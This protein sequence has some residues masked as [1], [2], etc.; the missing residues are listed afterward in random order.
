M[1]E[2]YHWL[3]QKKNLFWINLLVNNR[4]PKS[5]QYNLRKNV[6]DT[7]SQM[8]K[9]VQSLGLF[10]EEG[11]KEWYSSNLRKLALNNWS[12]WSISLLLVYADKSWSNVRFAYN[13]KYING[14]LID[15]ALKK[16]RLLLEIESSISNMSRINLIVMGLPFNIQDKLDKEEI[17]NT[18]LL[19]N[20]I[21]M[22][23]T[24]YNKQKREDKVKFNSNTI[25]A[26]VKSNVDKKKI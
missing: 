17:I 18:D 2:R 24:G 14:S 9:K 7:K 22:Y 26:T 25:T 20:R 6:T 11:A 19:M 13:Y 10:L 16:E 21:R 4:M 8:K 3:I 5:G 1:L 12:E 15:Y 23:E